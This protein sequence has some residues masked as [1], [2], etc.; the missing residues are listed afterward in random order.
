MLDLAFYQKIAPTLLDGA[1]VTIGLMAVS[2]PC[3]FVIA[4]PVALARV[5]ANRFLWAP[6]YAFIFFFRGTPLLVQLFLI[7]YGLGQFAVIR[8]SIAWPLL[9]EAWWCAVLALSLNTG[10]YTAEILRGAIQAVPHG[11]IEAGRACGMSPALIY[12]RLILPKAARLALP[13]YVNEIIMLL[14]S[15]ALV[16]TITVI[17]LMGAANL[18]RSR[19]FRI[20]EPLVAAGALYLA[21]TFAVRRVAAWVESA[22]A[23]ERRPPR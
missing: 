15:S 7:Y 22:L 4:L 17:D 6:A 16:F 20:Y 11:E 21:M 9:R 14:K 5:S 19:T 10:A 18:I 8:D 13:A 2:V 3:G 1:A 12:R 23:P